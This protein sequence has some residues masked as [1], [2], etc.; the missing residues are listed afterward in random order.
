MA[1]RVGAHAC[2][3]ALNRCS[4]LSACH[5]QA[6]EGAGSRPSGR[7][8]GQLMEEGRSTAEAT[9]GGAAHG[10]A[11]VS[12]LAAQRLGSA[13]RQQVEAGLAVDLLPALS[14]ALH[15]LLPH[16]LDLAGAPL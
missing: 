2:C 10:V 3:K 16:G 7:L 8:V 1:P 11:G 12:G 6:G 4:S 9:T 5:G 14:F 13:R 15:A